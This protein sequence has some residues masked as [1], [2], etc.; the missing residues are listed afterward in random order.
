MEEVVGRIEAMD[1]EP[2][3]LPKCRASRK[4]PIVPGPDVTNLKMES[5]MTVVCQ[6]PQIVARCGGAEPEK[7]GTGL[8][9]GDGR[10]LGPTGIC[11]KFL[12]AVQPYAGLLT[13]LLGTSP[14]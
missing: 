11:R 4:A 1:L 3:S 5:L 2:E 9:L 7:N 14:F 8:S 13:C 10:H 12:C 6:A